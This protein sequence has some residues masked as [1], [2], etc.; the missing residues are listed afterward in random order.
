MHV[1]GRVDALTDVTHRE[2]TTAGGKHWSFYQ[3]LATLALGGEQV[4]VAFR[5]D[6]PPAGPLFVAELDSIVKIKVEK[7][8]IFNG[9]ASFDACLA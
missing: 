6:T 7:P 9:K 3:Q 4:E 1:T 8:R 5:S 2:G